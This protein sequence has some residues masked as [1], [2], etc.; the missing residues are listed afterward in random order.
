MPANEKPP[1][2]P[3]DLYFV[4]LYSVL[5]ILIPYLNR[6]IC[7]IPI[8]QQKKFI[9]LIFCLFSV[10]PTFVDC[11]EN[12]L[13]LNLNGLSSIGLLGSQNGYTIVN[14]V[15]MYYIG[16]YLRKIDYKHFSFN[17]C[18]LLLL[19]NTLILCFWSYISKILNIESSAWNYSNPLVIINACL[20][21]LCFNF[22]KIKIHNLINN[23][24]KATF[25]V[26]LFHSYIIPFFNIK[27]YINDT[28]IFLIIFVI[29]SVII[30]YLIC[31]IIYIIYSNIEKIFILPIIQ[32]IA[33]LINKNYAF[34][35]NL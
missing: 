32:K 12:I 20:V 18:I 31:Y 35:K 4:I 16:G 26:F 29:I 14:F 17:K 11:I 13:N 6:V 8:N 1:A 24:S 19:I 30:I 27:N 33:Y 34:L 23:L 25:S 7:D 5:Y 2:R 28:L 22:K 9:T 15:L 3:V 10:Y 21:F